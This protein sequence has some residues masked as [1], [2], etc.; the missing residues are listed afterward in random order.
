MKCDEDADCESGFCDADGTCG[1]PHFCDDEVRN[2]RETDVDCG[3]PGCDTCADGKQCFINADC[4]NRFCDRSADPNAA[5]VCGRKPTCANGVKDGN[6]TDID[7]GGSDCPACGV[8]ERCNSIDDCGGQAFCVNRAGDGSDKKF[9]VECT[10]DDHCFIL[11]GDERPT[12]VS[13]TCTALGGTCSAGQDICKF[14]PGPRCGG[15]GCG[16]CHTTIEGATVCLNSITGQSCNNPCTSNAQCVNRFGPGA[17][18]IR[19]T[20]DFCGC[21]GCAFPC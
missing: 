19:D 11:H 13:Y 20:G 16:F 6:E 4:Q 17:V 1:E 3:G 10:T 15:T 18:C 9:C 14:G 2:G 7:C 5:G 21:N 12:C 8:G